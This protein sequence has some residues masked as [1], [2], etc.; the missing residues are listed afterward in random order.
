MDQHNNTT[1]RLAQILHSGGNITGGDEF[2]NF[3]EPFNTFNLVL[4]SIVG[5]ITTVA[6]IYFMFLIITGALAYM[7]A[8]G[9][10][11][12]LEEA[13]KKLMSGVAGLIIV[14]AAIF[15]VSLVGELMGIDF[16]NPGNIFESITI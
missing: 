10:K 1:N 5:V 12:R 3:S 11:G 8:G 9:D 14:I 15:I 2:I 16:L 7:G 6:I 4:P 13:R